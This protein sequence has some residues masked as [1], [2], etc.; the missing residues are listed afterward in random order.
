MRRLFSIGEAL[1][2][3]IPNITNAN[4]NELCRIH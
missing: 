4:L 2:D 3:F 1:I